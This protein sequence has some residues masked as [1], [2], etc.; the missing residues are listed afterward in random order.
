MLISWPGGWYRLIAVVFSI[1]TW[2]VSG[3]TIFDF[4]RHVTHKAEGFLDEL[5]LGLKTLRYGLNTV[6]GVLKESKDAECAFKCPN[7][8]LAKP[9]SGYKPIPN[10]CGSYGLKFDESGLPHKDMNSC[11]NRHDICYGTCLATKDDCD[12]KFLGCLDSVCDKKTG[13]NHKDKLMSKDPRVLAVSQQRLW[14][15]QT[16]VPLQVTLQCNSPRKFRQPEVAT[17]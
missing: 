4:A 5:K 12:S 6:E 9:K 14:M 2:Y 15:W 7:G 17:P 8:L 3:Q 1:A 10:G 16:P 11:C 13:K